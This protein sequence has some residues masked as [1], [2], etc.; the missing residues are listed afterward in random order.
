MHL[1]VVAVS[2]YWFTVMV[3]LDRFGWRRLTKG[4]G[5]G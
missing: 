3:F 2:F 4:E 1:V 5:L